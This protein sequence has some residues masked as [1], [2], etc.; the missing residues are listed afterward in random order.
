MIFKQYIVQNNQKEI[1]YESFI[2]F[3]QIFYKVVNNFL[4]IESMMLR[5]FFAFMVQRT[6]FLLCT[7]PARC[8]R[9]FHRPR[10][11]PWK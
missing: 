9:K 6:L 11:P 3:R 8:T 4:K 5:L 2:T 10:V 7:T 1:Y